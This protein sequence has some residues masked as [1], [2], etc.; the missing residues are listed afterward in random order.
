VSISSNFL[1][2]YV[3]LINKRPSHIDNCNCC[4]VDC[5]HKSDCEAVGYRKQQILQLSVCW[6]NNT[7]RKVS[8]CNVWQFVKDLQLLCKRV[9]IKYIFAFS[10][11]PFSWKVFR[12]DNCLMKACHSK[13]DSLSEFF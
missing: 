12:M 10:E 4:K 8:M 2:V 1:F 13:Y 11:L 3:V 5:K 7:Y 6:N 9:D